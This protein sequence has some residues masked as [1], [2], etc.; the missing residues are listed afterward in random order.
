MMSNYEKMKK[1]TQYINDT[2]KK[3]NTNPVY[4]I[5]N[6]SITI[7]ARDDRPINL[8]RLTRPQFSA[9]AEH[10]VK[11]EMKNSSWAY[12]LDYIQQKLL[13]SRMFVT[14]E[15]LFGPSDEMGTDDG[16]KTSFCFHFLLTFPW[17]KE[18]LGYLM[19]VHDLRGSIYYEFA[20][21]F[22]FDEQIDRRKIFYHTDDFTEEE[23]KYAVN[24]FYGYLERYFETYI[25]HSFD[26]F[27]YKTIRCE[28]GVYG[29]KDGVF[30]DKGY[31]DPD[32]YDIAIKT[33]SNYKRR[34]C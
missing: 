22:P 8:I 7:L 14:L 30:F 11:I 19:I 34:P 18:N 25:C 31:N 29:Y 24:Y 21:I 5:T 13:F 26:A 3:L 4:P 10:A 9:I 27:F 1:N 6:R 32:A 2:L 28:L 17:E 16:Y 23:R 20:K 12:S 15:D 33:L